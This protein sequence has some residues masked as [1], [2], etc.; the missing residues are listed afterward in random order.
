LSSTLKYYFQ[1][2]K[3]LFQ[4]LAIERLEQE[5]KQYPVLHFD[6]STA[7]NRDLAGIQSELDSQL[8]PYE[9][10]WNVQTETGKLPGQ[11]LSVL[12]KSLHAQTGT[13]TVVII[14]EYDA[15]MLDVLHDDVKLPEVRR[16]MQEFY[17]PLKACD[18]DLRF[19]FITGITK[20]S[21]LSIFS[22]INNLTNVS[23]QAD[24]ASICGITEEEL[25][26]VF[27]P[28]IA[29]LAE[30]YECTPQDM[31]R[32]LKER[33]DGYH[34][35]GKSADIYNPFSIL[36][37][38]AQKE[39]KDYWFESGTPTY[40]IR[41]IRHFQADI[42]SLDSIEATAPD[43]DRPTE[44]M[45]NVIPLLYQSGYITIRKYD[46]QWEKYTLGIPNNEV[47][48]GLTENLLPDYAYRDD[49]KNSSFVMRFCETVYNEEM[50]KAMVALRAY[51]AGI[52]Y[53]EG[54]KEILQDMEK[55]EYY[56]ETIFYLLFSF[57]N[58]HIQT[59]VK[60]CRGRA[61]MVMFT[62][63]AI[64]VFELKINKS[65]QE[66]IDQIDRKGYMIPY[67]ADGRKLVKC[68]I[69]F[70]TTTRTIEE[71]LVKEEA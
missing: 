59:Q 17:A 53:P 58:R 45:N 52:P 55:S 12:I 25:H 64:Y 6:L 3:D 18:A 4:G 35:S 56:Y 38:F 49:Y 34:F 43:F 70:S 19:V 13:K 62:A 39:I 65:A 23:L 44:T 63:K 51:L 61:D 20:F 67:T 30:E 41:Q 32:R 50:E 66:A 9:A 48:V 26:T 37:A 24:F 36:K 33:Y 1:G 28:D 21:Q 11:R 60:T 69:S 71:W 2:R 68:G 14:D 57:M 27:E 31:R 40:L 29:M 54:G 47:R 46:R 10:Q 8:R 16:M 7:K 22:V 15:P 42:L 5:W